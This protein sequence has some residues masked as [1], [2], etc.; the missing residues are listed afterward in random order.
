M[1]A[2]KL[3]VA[4][5]RVRINE[6]EVSEGLYK[7]LMIGS[8]TST[9]LPSRL[10]LIWYNP[11]TESDSKLRHILGT[12]F[13]L[14]NSITRQNQMTLEAACVPPMKV[15]FDTPVTITLSQ[16]DVRM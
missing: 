14:Y 4:K 12:F 8:I 15:L 5:L 6:T 1:R 10:L 9:K 11:M 7:L 16:I 13:T 3:E 2:K